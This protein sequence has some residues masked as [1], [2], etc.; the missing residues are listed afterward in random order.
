MIEDLNTNI[1]RRAAE[2]DASQ[3]GDPVFLNG[4]L[5]FPSGASREVSLRGMVYPPPEDP[6]QKARMIANYWEAR[7]Q[8]AVAAFDEL[9]KKLTDADWIAPEEV[10]KLK[11][12]QAA[13]LAMKAKHEAAAS[14]RDT[15]DP[16]N[17]VVELTP[18]QIASEASKRKYLEKM[19]SEIKAIEV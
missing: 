9:K 17:R 5:Y 8:T 10:S 4:I 18:E 16:R 13:A 12:A 15:L 14:E 6:F 19:R 7:M 3:G 11:A 2:W 1:K